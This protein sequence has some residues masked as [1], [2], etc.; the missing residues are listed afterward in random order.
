MRL[1]K[2]T[3]KAIHRAIMADVPKLF[4][5]D[6]AAKQE[7]Q[8]A[9][10]K[11][12]S[13]LARKLYKQNPAALAKR[14][15]SSWDYGFRSSVDLIVGDADSAA[16]LKPYKDAHDRRSSVGERIESV[17]EGCSTLKQL[18]ALLPEFEK[19]MPSE[20]AP[21]KNL[22]AVANIVSDLTKLGWPK[23]GAK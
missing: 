6:E 7:I 10:V 20:T 21:S 2:Y 13:P 16:V 8:E 17:I 18:K 1:D 22:P 4:T 23:G 12:M 3:K 14:H 19:Y 9:L 11:A 5:N 15:F